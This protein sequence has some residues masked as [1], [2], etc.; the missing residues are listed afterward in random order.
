MNPPRTLLSLTITRSLLA[1]LK[2][3]LIALLAAHAANYI[4][5]LLDGLE[6]LTWWPFESHQF[7]GFEGP[8]GQELW[9]YR[10]G[11]MLIHSDLPVEG[12][13]KTLWLKSRAYLLIY[14]AIA[15]VLCICLRKIVETV[16]ERDP[17]VQENVKQIRIMGALVLFHALVLELIKT[18]ASQPLIN[19]INGMHHPGLAAGAAYYSSSPYPVYLGLILLVFAEIFRQGIRLREEKAELQGKLMLKQKLETA[20]V[21]ADGIT[22]DFKN[23]LTSIIGYAEIAREENRDRNLSM[24]LDRML[25]SLHRAKKLVQ[26]IREFS[27]QGEDATD[28]ERINLKE[29]L[30]DLGASLAPVFPDSIQVVYDL[31]EEGSYPV[32]ADA[33]KIYQVLLNLSLNAVQAMEGRNGV[34]TFALT[35]EELDGEPFCHIRVSDTGCGMDPEVLEHIF[36]PYFTTKPAGEGAGLG[37]AMCYGIVL[38]HGGRI[39]AASEKGKGSAFDLY[40]PAAE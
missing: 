24:P 39:H 36:E 11:A 27:R 20:G 16:R 8:P 18:V 23:I 28:F 2:Y 37:L 30:E 12:M 29:E 9:F 25:R 38:S 7:L 33:T 4:G 26:T 22:H 19:E 35:R 1:F 6:F 15:L 10:E 21:L 14:M 32:L 17:F 5:V 13:M 34:L 40:L 31:P 3:L